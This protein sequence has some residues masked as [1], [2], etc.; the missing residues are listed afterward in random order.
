[1][2][3]PENGSIHSVL[4]SHCHCS[5]PLCHF[6]LSKMRFFGSLLLHPIFLGVIDTVS[7]QVTSVIAG[8]PPSATA[9]CQL[10][11]QGTAE[12][13][14]YPHDVANPDYIDG[15]THY[16]SSANADLT[17][18]CVV[19]PTTAEELSYVVTSLL[20]DRGEAQFFCADFFEKDWAGN[21]IPSQYDLVYDYTVSC[22]PCT[23]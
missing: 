4:S 22:Q 14:S 1:M 17:P 2:S 5:H 12:T 20:E 11:S 3:T 23:R 21:G 7:A 8:S 15:K 6:E 10:I 18:A 9:A 13:Q 19:F 16:W